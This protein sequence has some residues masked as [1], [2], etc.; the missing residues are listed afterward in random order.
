MNVGPSRSRSSASSEACGGGGPSA[1]GA[2]GTPSSC[3][4]S[5]ESLT[6]QEEAEQRPSRLAGSLGILAAGGWVIPTPTDAPGLP[7]QVRADV[8]ASIKEVV[9]A[10]GGVILGRAAAA[11]LAGHSRAY[12]VR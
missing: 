1:P 12:H 9:A 3:R 10:G 7:E 5:A 8:E 4:W 6:P 11:V 2:G